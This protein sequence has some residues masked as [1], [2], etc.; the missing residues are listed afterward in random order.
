[1]EITFNIRIIGIVTALSL[2]TYSSAFSQKHS[3]KGDRYFDKNLFEDA[4][5]YYQLEAKSG[6]RY[7]SIYAKQQLAACYRIIG[8]FELAEKTYKKILKSKRN[9][10][11]PTNFLNYGKSLKSSAK[12]AEAKIQFPNAGYFFV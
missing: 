5:K 10:K 3:N 11:D 7:F 4:I 6:N 9:R 8:E 12:Y 1:M 2:M